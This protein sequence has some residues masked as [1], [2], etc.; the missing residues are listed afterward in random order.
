MSHPSFGCGH[1]RNVI[2]YICAI[3]KARQEFDD[4]LFKTHIYDC[5]F[6]V[7]VWATKCRLLLSSWGHW[8]SRVWTR[9][10]VCFGGGGGKGLGMKPRLG[11]KRIHA[12]NKTSHLEN[13]V[14]E[15]YLMIQLRR[16]MYD[17][18]CGVTAP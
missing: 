12:H 17:E 13:A 7:V 16:N 2:K 6:L 1:Y 3:S 5:A 10:C 9:L 8:K 18:A 14:M 4:H 11:G 15:G